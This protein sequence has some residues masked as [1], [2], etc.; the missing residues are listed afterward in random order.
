MLSVDGTRIYK[1][2]IKDVFVLKLHNPVNYK[3]MYRFWEHLV[4][5]NKIFVYVTGRRCLS[6]F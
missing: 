4:F 3:K 1:K 2:I 6:Y 5:N